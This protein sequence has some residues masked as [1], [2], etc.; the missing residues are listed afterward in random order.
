[1]KLDDLKS[2]TM[3][4]YE[5]Y[6]PPKRDHITEALWSQFTPLN[7]PAGGTHHLVPEPTANIAL[8][9]RYNSLGN[10]TNE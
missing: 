8:S 2:Y 7:A 4:G 9:R 10:T 6:R 5:E 1:M 3:A